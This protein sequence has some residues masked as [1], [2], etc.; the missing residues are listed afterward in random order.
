MPM[1]AYVLRRYV[2]I[3]QL[4]DQRH[5]TAQMKWRVLDQNQMRVELASLL[6]GACRAAIDR[7][8]Q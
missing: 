5:V 1:L 2:R 4:I 7:Q 8:S 3:D 6:Q